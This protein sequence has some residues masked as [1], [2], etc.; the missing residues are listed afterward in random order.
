[1]APLRPISTKLLNMFQ[2]RYLYVNKRKM[3]L[4]GT[5]APH[6]HARLHGL[7]QSKA[8]A[9]ATCGAVLT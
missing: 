1:M 4:A 6:P 7:E 9:C 8:T 3:C 2:D 5:Q